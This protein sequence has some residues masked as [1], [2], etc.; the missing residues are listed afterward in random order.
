MQ[1]MLGGLNSLR[2]GYGPRVTN[3]PDTDVEARRNQSSSGSNTLSGTLNYD[4]VNSNTQQ[5]RPNGNRTMELHMVY[6]LIWCS[7]RIS[8]TTTN[9]SGE[10]KFTF[11][12]Q[13][14]G[15]FS[16]WAHFQIKILETPHPFSAEKIC[17]GKDLRQRVTQIYKLR[18]PKASA[19]RVRLVSEY[20][21][22]PLQLTA[23]LP[24]PTTQWQSVP[25]L[26]SLFKASVPQIPKALF[27]A[28]FSRWLTGGQVQKIYDSFGPKCPKLELT[29][30]NLI[31]CLLNGI[32]NVGFRKEGERAVWEADWDDCKLKKGREDFPNVKVVAK[33]QNDN[34]QVKYVLES[35]TLKFRDERQEQVVTPDNIEKIRWAIYL[36]L[37]VFG[38]KGEIEGHLAEG[39]LFTGEVAIPFFKY[40]TK[41]NPIYSHVGPCLDQ[42][43]WIN[44]LG[45][46]EPDGII[47]KGLDGSPIASQRE[48]GAGAN[49]GPG[50]KIMQDLLA[51]GVKKKA[52]WKRPLE[53]PLGEQDY[54]NHC[55]HVHYEMLHEYY[56]ELITN[57]QQKLT[58]HWHEIYAWSEAIYSRLPECPKITEREHNPEKKD[59]ENLAIF[60]ARVVSVPTLVHWIRHSRQRPYYSFGVRNKALDKNGRFAPDGNTSASDTND[61]YLITNTLLNFRAV[62]FLEDNNIPYELRNRFFRNLSKYKGYPDIQMMMGATKI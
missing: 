26:I 52:N 47:K 14:K 35:I 39:H 32:G 4:D 43:H 10:F 5:P 3:V 21:R 44:F 6:P 50:T 56:T 46:N 22:Q 12:D 30:E 38:L 16:G 42:A 48:P 9:P 45:V 49:G 34:G 40:I 8:Q 37:A 51:D 61:Q 53:T 29:G 19:A 2:R 18:I 27:V 17:G 28:T 25:Y 33:P 60:L 58:D 15:C 41:D 55:L 1:V 23:T 11:K 31:D 24:P 57:N 13:S 20:A 7:T 62:T 54:F 59:F 36:S